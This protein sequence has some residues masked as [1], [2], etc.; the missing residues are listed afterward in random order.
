M[1]TAAAGPAKNAE[2]WFRGLPPINLY[3]RQYAAHA[4]TVGI[5][6]SGRM[7][8]EAGEDIYGDQYVSVLALAD[9]LEPEVRRAIARR[10]IRL[11]TSFADGGK[12]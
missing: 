9:E 10:M 5:D 6:R 3:R 11:W 8:V 1:A 2:S 12:R 4:G 7:L